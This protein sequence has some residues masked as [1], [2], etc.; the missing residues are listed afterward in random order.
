MVISIKNDID[1]LKSLIPGLHCTMQTPLLI[2]EPEKSFP[3]LLK[4]ILLFLF[5]FGYS[6]GA[7]SQSKPWPVPATALTTKN[8]LVVDASIIKSGK[9]LYL[10][11]CAPCHGNSGKGDGIAA[12]ALTTKP[13]NH[14]SPIIQ[15]EPDGSLFFKITEGRTPMPKYKTVLT[16][17]QRWELVSYIK[18]LGKKK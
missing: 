2:S 15:A 14:T 10:S 3:L 12:A 8:P 1:H 9:T 13:A 17:A 5:L 18:T 7:F 6:N 16:D 4:P 11:Y